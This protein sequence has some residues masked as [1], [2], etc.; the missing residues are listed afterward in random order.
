MEIVSR[1]SGQL[2]ILLLT[3]FSIM[4]FAKML[5]LGGTLT[6]VA[7]LSSS[8]N[9]SL[10]GTLN[11]GGILSSKA[12]G[13]PFQPNSTYF[14]IVTSGCTTAELSQHS[15]A[16]QQIPMANSFMNNTGRSDMTG[17]S[18]I[19]PGGVQRN[20]FTY[21]QYLPD[22]TNRAMFEVT[23]VPIGCYNNISLANPDCLTAAQTVIGSSQVQPRW[24]EQ[25]LGADK[26]TTIVFQPDPPNEDGLSHFVSST[27][28]NCTAFFGIHLNRDTNLT[29]PANLI[30]DT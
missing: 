15:M 11:S 18:Y 30:P 5:A 21:I 9:F 24:R 7:A 25:Q 13:S 16:V 27:S 26:N 1:I 8:C 14:S 23:P 10:D 4:I 28:G 19:A 22:D 17:S 20:G 6:S 3:R 12:F 29:V 2:A